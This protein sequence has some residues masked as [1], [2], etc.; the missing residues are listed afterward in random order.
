MNEFRAVDSLDLFGKRWTIIHE[1]FVGNMV[2]QLLTF[3]ESITPDGDQ[4]EAQKQL[5]RKIVYS[6]SNEM[7]TTFRDSLDDLR[8]FHGHMDG[9]PEYDWNVNSRES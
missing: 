1:G 3:I 2:G 5:A 6:I 7:L 8:K 9:E 4:Q